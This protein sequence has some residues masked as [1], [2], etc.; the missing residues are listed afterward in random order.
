MAEALALDLNSEEP[1]ETHLKLAGL[2]TEARDSR[3]TEAFQTTQITINLPEDS[4][5]YK[6][7][8]VFFS[9]R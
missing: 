8:L 5:E 4:S 3:S 6:S 7:N 2:E 1:K 9:A